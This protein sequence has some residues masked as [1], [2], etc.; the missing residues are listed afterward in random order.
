VQLSRADIIR[1]FQVGLEH[2]HS[3]II[4]LAA[5]LAER[6]PGGV[7][8]LLRLALIPQSSG[9]KSGLDSQ[10]LANSLDYLMS[11]GFERDV[12]ALLDHPEAWVREGVAI[13]CGRWDSKESPFLTAYEEALIALALGRENS[14]R[15]HGLVRLLVHDDYHIRQDALKRLQRYDDKYTTEYLVDEL[16]LMLSECSDEWLT[17]VGALADPRFI[18]LLV[19]IFLGCPMQGRL[20]HRVP[21]QKKILSVLV[22]I[23]TPK[24]ATRLVELL[25]D[26]RNEVP[27]FTREA[28]AEFGSVASAPLLNAY[29]VASRM[30][31]TSAQAVAKAAGK[32]ALPLLLDA[33]RDAYAEVRANAVEGLKV[34]G[35]EAVPPLIEFVGRESGDGRTDAIRAL[36]IIGDPRAAES[37]AQ[38]AVTADGQLKPT[39]LESLGRIEASAS[40]QALQASSRHA[41]R[42]IRMATARALQTYPARDALHLLVEIL[43]NDP[44]PR[45]RTATVESLA[46]WMLS[47]QD[48]GGL[49]ALIK[50]LDDPDEGVRDTA[51]AVLVRFEER[52]LRFLQSAGGAS[53]KSDRLDDVVERIHDRIH[54]REMRFSPLPEPETTTS[55]PGPVTDAVQFT[56]VAPARLT[57][58]QVAPLDVFAHTGVDVTHIVQR[59][60]LEYG[61][62]IRH[63]TKGPVPV[64]RGSV[65]RVCVVVPSLQFADNDL[66]HWTGSLGNANFVLRVPE[67]ATI[68]QHEGTVHVMLDEADIARLRFVLDVGETSLT[69]ADVTSTMERVRSAFASY[70]SEDRERVLARVQGMQK[71]LP[72]LD[73]FV[74]VVALR[75]GER[76]KDRLQEEILARD[77]F[78]LFWSEAAMKSHWVEF[79]WRYA[80]Q[81]RGEYFINPVPL[82]PPELAPPPAE[83]RSLHFRDWTLF[84]DGTRSAA[85]AA[86]SRPKSTSARTPKTS[87]SARPL[88]PTKR[89][90]SRP[91]K[92]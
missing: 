80:L 68:C 44:H 39:L 64:E 27:Y 90:P 2:V 3:K 37:L 83:L 23:G 22:R 7:S 69:S 13:S 87:R 76:W 8:E 50:S 55:L 29:G 59:A 26:D 70:A 34:L 88:R 49:E 56:V 33:L 6:Q 79:E 77:V 62:Q 85:R 84:A 82:S 75:S 31:R 67:A 53:L 16:Q 86:A 21:L 11:D 32:R 58:G 89:T 78:Y 10:L 41:S 81:A 1:L 46:V 36:G 14:G 12:R 63:R 30:R 42:H 24:A 47:R 71:V 4:V 25:D 74:D 52:L 54:Q 40:W 28:L 38:L 72:D 51:A 15:K 60:G 20:S 45:V 48:D 92:R 57:R 19:A 61:S 5:R 9:K 17:Y 73:V 35:S 91:T 66:V 65:L 43:E 18:D